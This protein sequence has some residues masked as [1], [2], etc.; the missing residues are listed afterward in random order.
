MTSG[1]ILVLSI[2]WAALSAALLIC[3]PDV[4]PS[5]GTVILHPRPVI[6]EL[7]LQPQRFP[8]FSLQSD[9]LS[10]PLIYAP[11]LSRFRK[12]QF[13]MNLIAVAKQADMQPS[14]ARLIHQ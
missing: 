12:F 7:E 14:E 1:R 8:G 2:S 5:E 3:A 6:Q 9:P 13:G 10:A 4:K 11:D